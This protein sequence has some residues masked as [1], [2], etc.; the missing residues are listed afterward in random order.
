MKLKNTDLIPLLHGAALAVD[1]KN[2]YL[3]LYRFHRDQLAYYKTAKDPKKAAF[4]GKARASSGIRLCFHT[5]SPFFSFKFYV[6]QAA[7]RTFYAFD[8]VV[9]GV[10]C[11]HQGEKEVFEG[12]GT[13]RVA[14]PEG[15]HQVTVYCPMLFATEIADFT[16]ADGAA[17]TPVERSRRMLVLGDSLTQGYDALF[18]SLAYANVLADLLDATAIN[19]GIGGEIFNPDMPH[20]SLGFEVDM[21]LVSYGQN[22]YTKCTREE[23]TE[24]ATG[25]YRRLRRTYP[26]A[27]IFA[28]L[29]V[30]RTDCDKIHAMSYEETIAIAKK[31]ALSVGAIPI[32]GM[33]VI[34]HMREFYSN[35]KTPHPND[36]GMRFC[37]NGIYAAIKPYLDK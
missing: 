4:F 33:R 29:P 5:D 15:E 8:V 28:L 24:N 31:A 9:D 30:W 22:D 36:L 26:D 32:D 23:M 10:L 12:A 19:Q 37:A 35:S 14:L 6:K 20:P 3:A 16:V 27:P 25:F 7:N 17:V 21:I 34:P 11:H 18:P 1:Q 2:G 13:V